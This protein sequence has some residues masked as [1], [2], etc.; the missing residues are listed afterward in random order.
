VRLDQPEALAETGERA[1]KRFQVGAALSQAERVHGQLRAAG[2][3][4]NRAFGGSSQRGDAFGHVIDVATEI[5][6]NLVEQFVPGD[7]VRALHV[8]VRLLGLE[9]QIDRVRQ[10]GVQDR[11]D[12]GAGLGGKATTD[13]PCRSVYCTAV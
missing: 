7:E 3:G 13:W 10:A 1:R 5:A 8:P 12:L 2:H 9:L 6:G 11:D 4:L